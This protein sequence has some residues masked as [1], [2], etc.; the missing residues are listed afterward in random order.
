[1]RLLSVS[2]LFLLTSCASGYHSYSDG[3]FHADIYRD[4]SPVCPVGYIYNNSDKLCHETLSSNNNLNQYTISKTSSQ[5]VYTPDT[6]VKLQKTI[7]HK[8]KPAKRLI[9]CVKALAYCGVSK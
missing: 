1:M 5:I 2:V 4:Q 7:V 9:D 6:E 3:K 8:H